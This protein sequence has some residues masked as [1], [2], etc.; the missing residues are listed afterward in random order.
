MWVRDEE[1][2]RPTNGGS[3]KERVRSRA[4]Y[5]ELGGMRGRKEGAELGTALHGIRRMSR[6]ALGEVLRT[7]RWNS[8]DFNKSFLTP[9]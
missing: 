7:R 3:E 9:L 5:F 8:D 1:R 4:G 6:D 2:D